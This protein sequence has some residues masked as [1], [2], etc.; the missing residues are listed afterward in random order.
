MTLFAATLTFI[1]G[2][3]I[4]SFLSVVLYRL[5][6]KNKPIIFGR[7]ICQHSGKKLRALHLVPVL[8][9]MFLRGRSAYTGEKISVNYILLEVITGLTF[10]TIF[11]TFNF[12]DATAS[13]IDPNIFNYSIVWPTFANFI[14]HLAIF[15]FFIIIFFYD[16]V[17]K[18]IPDQ[19]SIP[20]IALAVAGSLIFGLP[21]ITSMLIGSVSIAGFFA[22]QFVIS[23]GTWVGGGDIRLGALIGAF[24]GGNWESL[25]LYLPILSE[26]YSQ[27]YYF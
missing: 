24:L 3:F 23:K 5:D 14:F 2:T 18:E 1:F 26:Q 16:L 6:H 13:N 25:L 15:S 12:V 17:H 20:A 11:F 9:W 10:L 22:L 21:P 7:S 8:S 19:I 27:Q 4:G